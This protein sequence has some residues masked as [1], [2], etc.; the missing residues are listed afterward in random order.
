MPPSA[1]SAAFALAVYAYFNAVFALYWAFLVPRE[2]L[3]AGVLPLV[4]Y[5]L[6]SA[7]H[8]GDRR[9]ALL[10][11]AALLL[12]FALPHSLLARAS[13]KR[14][15]R[16]PEAWERPAYVLQSAALL[17]MQMAAWRDFDGLG[18]LWDAR[19]SAA[20]TAAILAVYALGVAFLATASF[21]LDHFHLVGLSQGLG[22]DVNRALRLAPARGSGLVVRAHYALVAHPIMTGMLVCLWAT[23]VMAA[24]RLLLAAC[25]TAYIVLAVKLLEEPELVAAL[26]APYERYL[27]RVPSFC[28]FAPPAR[29]RA[30]PVASKE[31]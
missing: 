1:L 7:P 27:E 6:S 12:A 25:S 13:V 17:H 2:L 3:P 5:S 18:P 21:A 26:G 15:L 29:R 28:P 20:L 22:V 14:A 11:D 4:P 19:G 16:L 24:P 8:D 23:P 30:A 31:M 9:R 10:C